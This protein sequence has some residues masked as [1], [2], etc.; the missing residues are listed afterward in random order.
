MEILSELKLQTINSPPSGFKA[1]LI[2]VFPTSRSASNLPDF[3][4]IEATCAEP[5]QETNALLLSGK[6][7]MSSGRWQAAIV[8]RTRRFPAS[9]SETVLSPRLLTTTVAP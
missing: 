2:G 4:S 3:K 6:I 5:E 9:I 7:A 8:L 1:R